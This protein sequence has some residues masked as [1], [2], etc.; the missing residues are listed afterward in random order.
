MK[1]KYKFYQKGS[2]TELAVSTERESLCSFT[3]L[4]LWS[5][6]AE[7]YR[8]LYRSH[9]AVIHVNIFHDHF[10]SPDSSG[11]VHSIMTAFYFSLLQP[12][13]SVCYKEFYSY[14]RG[15]KKEKKNGN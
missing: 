10:F 4:R 14:H 3:T 11:Y 12:H 5:F 15:G 7:H 13:D 1:Y 2:F 9:C 8:L 6:H